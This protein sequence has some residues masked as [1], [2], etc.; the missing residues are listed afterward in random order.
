MMAMPP[1]TAI[2]LPSPSLLVHPAKRSFRAGEDQIGGGRYSPIAAMLHPQPLHV[3]RDRGVSS[4]PLSSPS[5]RVFS[6]DERE[7][8]RTLPWQT[9]HKRRSLLPIPDVLPV[10]VTLFG[11]TM[12]TAREKVLEKLRRDRFRFRTRRANFL[13]PQF[14]FALEP[15]HASLFCLRPYR[16]RLCGC[17]RCDA[18]FRGAALPDGKAMP[19]GKLQK[20]LHLCAGLPVSAAQQRPALKPL[21]AKAEKILEASNVS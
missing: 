6:K 16:R 10:Q 5:E 17:S 13:R 7:L 2:R 9:P 8:A 20:G 21:D 15:S 1:R 18:C 14:H 19:L 4:V 11:D 12:V 3:G